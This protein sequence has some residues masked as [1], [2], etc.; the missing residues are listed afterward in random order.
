MP[1]TDHS[2]SNAI[3]VTFEAL[4]ARD[5]LNRC[6]S[7]KGG[8]F[9]T[10]R[11]RSPAEDYKIARVFAI[12]IGWETNGGHVGDVAINFDQSDI[13]DV[14]F[15][16]V[17]TVSCHLPDVKQNGRAIVFYIVLAQRY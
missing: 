9:A 8:P 2:H 16:V 14:R 3:W 1:C 6:L 13:I 12:F 15:S 5:K 7:Q 10:F 17:V 4:G 11:R